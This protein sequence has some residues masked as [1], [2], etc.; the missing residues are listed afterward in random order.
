MSA[1]TPSELRDDLSTGLF[2]PEP[3][4]P[5]WPLPK[6]IE[7]GKIYEIMPSG[8][9]FVAR[10]CHVVAPFAITPH[11]FVTIS[12]NPLFLSTEPLAA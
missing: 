4:C 8:Y 1:G 5:D 7:E 11:S 10:S 12:V 2:L 3:V 6:R 9:L